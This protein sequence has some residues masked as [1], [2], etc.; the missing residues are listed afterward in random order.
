VESP[1]DPTPPAP[2]DTA[3]RGPVWARSA[4]R[5]AAL[6]ACLAALV[7]V[8]TERY[9]GSAGSNSAGASSCVPAHL[10]PL[11]EVGVYRLANLRAGL[12]AVVARAGGSRYA[13]GTAEPLAPWSDASPQPPGRTRGADGRWPAAYEIRQWSSE[14]DDVASDAF[15]F[16]DDSQASRFYDDASKA[17][18]HRAGAS[19]SAI[20]PAQA[21]ILTW[22]NPDRAPETD[23]LMLRST[24]VYRVV[25]VR[26]DRLPRLSPAQTAKVTVAT[27][28]RLACEL[29][30]A[31]CTRALTL[32]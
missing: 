10:P 16:T 19:S 8:A 30:D 28:S 22:V 3:R 12:L 25:V 20:D 5:L 6:L 7:G 11:A 26:G 21:R 4:V 27:A 32:S 13:A 2:R 18:C 24:R 14:G 9:V 29:P 1:V 31:G 17:R 23:V 15:E